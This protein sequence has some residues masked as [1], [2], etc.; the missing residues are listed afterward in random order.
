MFY[1]KI[2]QNIAFKLNFWLKTLYFKTGTSNFQHL[3]Y[4]YTEYTNNND[5]S[6]LFIMHF[7]FLNKNSNC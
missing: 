3:F 4:K 6:N 7:K 5:I 1:L 2:L